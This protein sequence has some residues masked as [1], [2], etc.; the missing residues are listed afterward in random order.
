VVIAPAVEMV[1]VPPEP[2]ALYSFRPEPPDDLR[3]IDQ[4]TTLAAAKSQADS[5][6]LAHPE[7][8]IDVLEVRSAQPGDEGGSFTEVV[9]HLGADV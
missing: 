4:V 5:Y 2:M 7:S 6:A 1:I 3:P 8:S 9:Y